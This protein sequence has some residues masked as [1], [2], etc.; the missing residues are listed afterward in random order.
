[1][2]AR[3][4]WVLI[5]TAIVL[6]VVGVS[7]SAP[8]RAV[9]DIAVRGLRCEYAVDP[10]GVDVVH[11]RLLW[12]LSSPRRGDRQ[13]AYQILVASS[14]QRLEQDNGDLWDSGKVSS[15]DTAHV[16]YRGVPLASSQ[17]VFWKVR[18]WDA[19]GVQSGWSEPASWTMGILDEKDWSARW[20]ADPGHSE[21]VLLRRAFT[22]KPGL[23]RALVHV[24]GLGQYELS[25]NGTRANAD[26]LTPG[27][28]KYDR[29]C[30]YD[31]RDV[32]TFVREGQ[33]AMG[34]L[35]GNGMYRVHGGRYKKF[36]GSFGELKAIVHLRLE[37]ADGG[38]EIVGS[39]ERWQ[40]HPGPITFSCVYGGED[41]DA[42]AQPHGWNTAGFDASAWKAAVVVDGP[43]GTLK[44]LTHA[45]PPIVT[46]DALTPREVKRFGEATVVYDLGQNAA[47]MPR[48]A[49][50]GPSGSRVRITP[51]ELLHEDGTIDRGSVG[52]GEAYWQ[53]TLAGDDTEHW[54]PK[55]FYHGARY[56]QVE[57]FPASA[58]GPLP[59]VESLEGVIVHSSS[60]SIGGFESSSGLFNLIHQLVLWA[61]RSNMV[62]VLTD[63]P[64]RERL[65]WLEQYHL[66]GPSLRYGFDLS[67]LFRKGMNDMADS[68]LPNGLV[69]DIAPEYTVF[70]D[71]FRDSP[72]W[73]G[74]FVLV[75]WQQYQWTGDIAPLREHY[76]AM[77]R[78]V[79]YLGTRAKNHIVSHGLGDWYDIGPKPPGVAQL[80]PIA[81]TATAFYYQD[82][83][84]LADAAALLGR[85]DDAKRYKQLGEQIRQS[86]NARFYD[87]AKRSY[88]TGSQ[89]A[90]AIPLVM[91]LVPDA[92]RGAVLDALVRD[93]R[94]HGNALTAGDVGYRYLLRALAEGGRSDVIFDMNHQSETPGYGY[95]LKTGAT[96]LT[97]AWNA[98]RRSSQNHFM[99]G[100]IV[101]WFYRDLAG[102]ATDP[103]GPGFARIRIAP[104]PVGD[105]TWV[106]AHVDTI[107]GRVAAEWTKEAGRFT[108][109]AEVPANTS[110][111]VVLPVP[112]SASVTIDGKAA[113]TQTAAREARDS[114]PHA[115]FRVGAGT[116]EFET[117]I[118]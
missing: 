112:S 72:E 58:G 90:N 17:Q 33:N 111:L 53:Y 49:V 41:Y 110:A 91:H 42:R 14:R 34:L 9:T 117:A 29:T 81:L 45:A 106:K 75:P 52:G 85:A 57:R 27:W 13:T 4:R 36:T 96:S 77:T 2:T 16:P 84:I 60:P 116:W 87:P 104:Q 71:G 10:L 28:T 70:E 102:I 19:D 43:G 40:V 64:H 44:G 113:A 115:A 109:K 54:F 23:T 55:F 1:M 37:Y 51:A 107:R 63:C 61:Q 8:T 5:A 99:L 114:G 93:V 62:S 100:Q 32:T 20:I 18:V 97:E 56:L 30:L 103:D 118:N 46:H 38:S 59:V 88:A 12:T 47:M 101:E 3:H 21:T 26:V 22:V 92:D 66:N 95:Q 94:Q 79:A 89:T 82:V 98:D 69:P 105:L 48:L 74:A 86:F 31:T 39:D 24:S 76:D 78:Y 11:P 50:R 25:L 65:G 67:R 108:L 7:G 83:R 15:S 80:T 35:L 73:G 68:Q 6:Q